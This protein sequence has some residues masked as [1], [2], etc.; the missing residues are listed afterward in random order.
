LTVD[1][2]PW[3]TFM[4]IIDS[5]SNIMKN[6]LTIAVLSLGWVFLGL[7]FL[8]NFY[9]SQLSD[10]VK[11]YYKPIAWDNQVQMFNG[12]LQCTLTDKELVKRK[13]ILRDQIFSRVSERKENTDGIVY[14]FEYDKHLL[15]KVLEHIQIEKECCPFFKFDISILP[16]N[17]GIV[18][19]IS[20][21]EAAIEMLKEFERET[22]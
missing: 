1:Y 11:S 2:S 5:V 9:F 6:K 21:S 18:L 19:G 12:V 7:I 16:F 3:F 8:S 22:I 20:G 17:K 14:Y 15:N 10:G 4:A 13:E